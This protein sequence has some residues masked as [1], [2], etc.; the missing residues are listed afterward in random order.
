MRNTNDPIG[1]PN[2]DLPAYSAVRQPTAPPRT[3][4]APEGR[5]NKTNFLM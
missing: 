5:M 3:L 2:R 4:R 1:N